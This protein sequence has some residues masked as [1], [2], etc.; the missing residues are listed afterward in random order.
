MDGCFSL[1]PPKIE[2]IDETP[3]REK[4]N[5]LKPKGSKIILLI[6]LIFYWLKLILM[7][8]LKIVFAFGQKIIAWERIFFC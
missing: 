7:V 5:F 3:K 6:E 8:A 1:N 2:I 4:F